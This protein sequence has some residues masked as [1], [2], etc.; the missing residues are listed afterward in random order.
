MGVFT[1]LWN[2]NFIFARKHGETLLVKTVKSDFKEYF[3]LR[4]KKSLSGFSRVNNNI[5]S[6]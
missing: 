5:S 6:M 1:L 2:V 3:I 4:K